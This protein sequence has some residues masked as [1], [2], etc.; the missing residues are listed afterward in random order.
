MTRWRTEGSPGEDGTVKIGHGP[1]TPACGVRSLHGREVEMGYWMIEVSRVGE[2]EAPLLAVLH[3]TILGGKGETLTVAEDEIAVIAHL[4]G[5]PLGFGI[6]RVVGKVC[7]VRACGVM[8]EY[9]R[10]G[11]GGRVVA[12]VAGL[13]RTAGC[14]RVAMEVPEHCEEMM[15]LARSLK[16]DSE[17]RVGEGTGARVRFEKG[18]GR[19]G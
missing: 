13:G 3:E 7:E 19:S 17:V 18:L 9:R 8:Q 14:E 10:Q 5:N 11:I 12:M 15:G 1:G 2:A 6:G 16:F 4:E